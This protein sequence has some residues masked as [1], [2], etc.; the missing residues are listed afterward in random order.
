MNLGIHVAKAPCHG[1]STRLLSTRRLIPVMPAGGCKGAVGGGEAFNEGILC[2]S[3]L[4]THCCNSLS[5]LSAVHL[6]REYF[7][8]LEVGG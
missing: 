1:G 7:A 4:P 3:T 6:D 2:G 5:D 8:M